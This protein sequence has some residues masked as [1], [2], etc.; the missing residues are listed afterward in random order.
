[1]WPCRCQLT[2]IPGTAGTTTG[3]STGIGSANNRYWGSTFEILVYDRV[4]TQAEREKVEAYLKTKWA[5]PSGGCMPGK[6]SDL[7]ALSTAVAAPTDLI[8]VID[9][10]DTS[11]AATGTN[12]KMALANM[13]KFTR[14]GMAHTHGVIVPDFGYVPGMD[15][16]LNVG[17]ATNAGGGGQ[18]LNAVLNHP[19]GMTFYVP[20][21][22]AHDCVISDLGFYRGST[23]AADRKYRFSLYASRANALGPGALITNIGEITVPNA[24]AGGYKYL[25]GLS[26][27]VRAATLYWM[28]FLPDSTNNGTE[29]WGTAGNNYS[30]NSA[31]AFVFGLNTGYVTPG[32]DASAANAQQGWGGPYLFF[33]VSS[34]S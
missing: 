2:L 27:S 8:E 14:G 6:I 23:A 19:A 25:T 30:C 32:A 20:C 24:A 16:H 15:Y 33:K 28:G 21:V 11:M 12:K 29:W 10:S 13:S 18:T 34:S 22:F 9:V 31:N 1:M 4:L 5:T 17:L 3:L 7:T 26:V